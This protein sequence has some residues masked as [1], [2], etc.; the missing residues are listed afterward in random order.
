[1][2]KIFTYNLYINVIRPKPQRSSAILE[3]SRSNMFLKNLGSAGFCLKYSRRCGA[4]TKFTTICFSTR[5]SG[6]VIPVKDSLC[7]KTHTKS[8]GTWSQ[9]VA[10][11]PLHILVTCPRSEHFT[12]LSK[13]KDTVRITY[14][15][16]IGRSKLISVTYVGTSQVNG[17]LPCASTM[18]YTAALG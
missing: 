12:K 1:M 18:H 8:D 10:A 7:E 2:L 5:P 3:G 6:P 17:R 13:E 14:Y 16:N 15:G 4:W 11:P 9:K